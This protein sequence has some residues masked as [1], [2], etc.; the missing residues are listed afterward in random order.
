MPRVGWR[1]SWYVEDLLYFLLHDLAP[2]EE[3]QQKLSKKT[4]DLFYQIFSIGGGEE[5]KIETRWDGRCST[6]FTQ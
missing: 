2:I 6:G 4:T 3:M 1:S 5:E